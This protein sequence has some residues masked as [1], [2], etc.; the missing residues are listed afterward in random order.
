MANTKKT[1]KKVAAKAPVKRVNNKKDN[2]KHI[3]A[4]F[5][6]GMCLTTLLYSAFILICAAS[7]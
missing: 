1:T 5:L 3:F 2:W 6:L 7:I 4:G